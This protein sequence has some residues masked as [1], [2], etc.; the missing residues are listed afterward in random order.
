[1]IKNFTD[2]AAN[3]RTYLAWIRTGV[4]VMAFGFLVEKFD[5]FLFYIAQALHKKTPAH[6][7]LHYAQA[8]GMGLVLIGI[9]MMTAATARFAWLS[10]EIDSPVPRNRDNPWPGVLAGSVL[11][12]MGVL[13]LFYLAHLNSGS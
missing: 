3:E 8:L 7:G 1:M 6:S 5:I 12:G 4:A 13:L 2:H 9:L 11:V 10:H